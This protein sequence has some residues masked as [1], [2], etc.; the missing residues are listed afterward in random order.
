[1]L[2]NI[3]ALDKVWRY[4]YDKVMYFGTNTPIDKCYDCGFEGEFE[5]TDTG[6]KCPQCGNT[7]PETTSCCRRQCG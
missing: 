4:S 6:F 5:A 7:S 3:E 1:M 2:N